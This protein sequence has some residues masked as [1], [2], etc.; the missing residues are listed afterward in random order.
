MKNLNIFSSQTCNFKI[1]YKSMLSNIEQQYI[2]FFL[3]GTKK[4]LIDADLNITCRAHYSKS[5]FWIIDDLQ[6]RLEEDKS[7][8]SD[9]F[10]FGGQLWRLSLG[11]VEL[12]D[13][14]YIDVGLSRLAVAKK[15]SPFSFIY[16]YS[17]ILDRNDTWDYYRKGEITLD[18][19]FAEWKIV[20]DWSGP[21][22]TY[23]NQEKDLYMPHNLLTIAFCLRW[24]PESELIFYVGESR[25]RYIITNK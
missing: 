6:R 2:H 7:L 19:T 17:G 16:W 5:A 14:Q 22:S 9:T 11:A 1:T 18:E 8:L 25:D 13:T 10:F 3:S 23:L 4:K 12:L 20:T 24:T 15:L 21:A